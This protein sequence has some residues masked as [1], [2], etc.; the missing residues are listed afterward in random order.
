[1]TN[2]TRIGD[3]GNGFCYAGHPDVPVGSPKEF[4]T[5]FISG[6]TT[7]FLNNVALVF[8]TS[9]GDTDCGHTTTAVAGSTTVYAEN[10]AVHRLGDLG[11]INEGDGD[12]TV[13]SASDNVGAGG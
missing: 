4:V 7:V 5:T 2:I 13:I 6:A 3:L 11:V 8:V 9:L 10:Q 1:M 12:Y